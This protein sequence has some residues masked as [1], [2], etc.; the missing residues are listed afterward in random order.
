M[1]NSIPKTGLK[2][3]KENWKDDLQAGFSV[4]LIA[5][6]LCLGISLASGFPPVAGILTAI[7]GGLLVSRIGGSFV[8]INGPAA[9]LIVISLG[10]ATD[11]GGAGEAAGYAGYPHAL[12]AIVVAG[13]FMAL[14]GLLKVGKLGDFF[15]SAAVHGMLAAIG[16]IIIIKQLYDAFG[17]KA[18]S[19]GIINQLLEIPTRIPDINS[20]AAIVAGVSLLTLIVHPM[21]KVK[22]IKAIPAPIWVLIFAIPLGMALDMDGSLLVNLPDNLSESIVF[23]S[24]EKIGESA[25]WVGVTGFALVSAIESLLSALAVDS[26]DPY[27]R[28][29]NLDKDLVGVGAGSSIAA[30]I[31]GLPMIAEIV[32]SSANINNGA[33]T[34]WANFFH[35][36]FLLIYLVI[37]AAVIELIPLSA[38]AAMLVFTGFRLASPKEFKHM[39]EIGKGQFLIFLTTIVTVLFTDLLIGIAA[40]IVLKIIIQ[41]IYGA[42]LNNLFVSRLSSSSEEDKL[43]IA[44]IGALI[45]SNYLSF[46]SQV[47]KLIEG[48]EVVE[49]DF[50]DVTLVDHTFQTHLAGLM[51]NWEEQGIKVDKINL[52]HMRSVS[53]Y[54]TAPKVKIKGAK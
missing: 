22:F 20:S 25:F 14:F 42:K 15:P 13:A 31:G 16:I 34:S 54:D 39:Y 45:F 10:A 44:P 43:T 28:K 8:T 2:G 46:K 36:S 5:L 1:K 49:F 23:P 32:R 53:N 29:T 52:G 48:Q 18:E 40:G 30:A 37:G 26:Q 12:G 19:K 41:I 6:P 3:L 7:V 38:L 47:L 35:G 33:K 4:S 17:I 51:K 24:F 50:S 9:G 27:N 11:L 21:L